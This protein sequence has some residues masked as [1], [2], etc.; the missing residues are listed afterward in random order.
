M[1]RHGRLVVLAS[2]PWSAQ[3]RHLCFDFH[4]IED[5]FGIVVNINM[6]R[7]GIYKAGF[8]RFGDA[9]DA[10]VQVRLVV[11]RICLALVLAVAVALAARSDVAVVLW[12]G[13]SFSLAA[14]GLLPVVTLGLRWKRA[15][16]Q[17][18]LAGMAVGVALC[19]YY[20]FAPR[21]I[22]VAFYETSSE[23]SC[24]EGSL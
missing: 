21:Y 8:L 6:T 11:A 16:A 5:W 24:A 2:V 13:L 19:L 12:S 17:G 9:P 10:T 4:M 23:L 15:N 3:V 14:S 18:A 1:Y 7:S 22:P 20:F